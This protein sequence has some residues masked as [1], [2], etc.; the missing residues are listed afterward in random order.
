MS[1]YLKIVREVLRRLLAFCMPRVVFALGDLLLDF[2]ISFL[3][4]D[5]HFVIALA[6]AHIP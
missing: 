2:G 1:R 6:T 3:D 5:S 4:V